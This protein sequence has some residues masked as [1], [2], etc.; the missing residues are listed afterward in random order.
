MA[1]TW[2]CDP[3][4]EKKVVRL[5][6]QDCTMIDSGGQVWRILDI[7]TAQVKKAE[8]QC[9]SGRISIDDLFIK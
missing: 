2:D 3:L 4:D 6:L 1:S 7:P 8:D 5:L 9:R